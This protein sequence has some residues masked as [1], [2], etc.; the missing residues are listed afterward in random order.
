MI[1]NLQE[2][3]HQGKGKQSKGAEICASNR[4]NLAV[5]NAPKLSAKCLEDKI[6]KIKKYKTFQ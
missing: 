4:Q 6:F 1:K 5:K 3:L 2:M